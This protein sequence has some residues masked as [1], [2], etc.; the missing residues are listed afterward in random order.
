MKKT[1][2]T[3]GDLVVLAL[4]GASHMNGIAIVLSA[5]ELCTFRGRSMM[6]QCKLFVFEKNCYEFKVYSLS[7]TVY[8]RPV[9]SPS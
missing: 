5:D 7:D 9:S 8:L 4:P 1:R 3:P 2:L 6:Q